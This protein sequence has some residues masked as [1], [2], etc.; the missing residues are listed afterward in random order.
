MF[1]SFARTNVGRRKSFNINELNE[2]GKAPLHMIEGIT[3]EDN[4]DTILQL[5][6]ILFVYGAY[7]NVRDKN[8]TLC[9]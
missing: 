4:I 7:P 6:Q 5:I 3:Y 2:E 1:K 8:E 9:C